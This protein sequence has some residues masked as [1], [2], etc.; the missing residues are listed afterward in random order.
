[1]CSSSESP[2][3]LPTSTAGVHIDGQVENRLD[4][5][6]AMKA[7]L[8]LFDLFVRARHAGRRL[9][10]RTA[11][12]ARST[13]KTATNNPVRAWRIDRAVGPC[14]SL[15][16]LLVTLLLIVGCSEKLDLTQSHEAAPA[17]DRKPVASVADAQSDAESPAGSMCQAANH[18]VHLA[19]QDPRNAVALLIR[20][21]DLHLRCG[22]FGL[23]ENDLRLAVEMAPES[24]SA[25]RALA[26]L[27]CAQ[28]RRV[29]ASKHIEQLIRLRDIKPTEVLSLVERRG[30][31]RLVSYD[32]LVKSAQLSL[33]DLGQLRQ[34]HAMNADLQQILTD[35]EKLRTAFP[36]SSAVA[37]FQGRLLVEMGQFDRFA[38][39]L[40][41]LPET[42]SD[43]PEYWSS[44]GTWL[45]EAD[46]HA[47]S[48]RAFGEAIRLDP[49]DRYSLRG[50]IGSLDS[51]SD[52]Q[53]SDDYELPDARELSTRL[54]QQLSIL[55]QIF[56]IAMNADPEQSQWIA[57]QMQELGRPWESLAWL[58]VAATKS[59]TLEAQQ[60]TLER[61]YQKIADW[62]HQASPDQIC[63]ARI[64]HFLGFQPRQFPLPDLADIAS[65]DRIPSR[66]QRSASFE[67]IDITTQSGLIATYDDSL[68]DHEV[69]QFAYQVNGSGVAVLDYD[70]DG[71]ADV[72]VVQAGGDP[73][74]RHGAE[75]NQ[76]FRLLPDQTYC[77]VSSLTATGDT[78]FGQGICAGDA[79]QDGF[80]DLIVANLGANSLYLN[81]GDG[82][83]RKVDD[84][85]RDD[86]ATWTSSIALADLNGDH[87]PEI[88]EI[89]YLDDA[90]AFDV[91]CEPN[92]LAC[93]P[94]QFNSAIDRV[95][96]GRT[97]GYFEASEMID[98]ANADAKLGFGVIVANF[99]Q[100]F[101]NDFFVSNDGDLNH[102]WKSDRDPDSDDPGYQLR[103]FAG[104]N[105]TS[106]GRN[107]NSQACMGI[108][109]ADFNR[110]GRLDLHVT[111]FHH[112]AVNLFVQ[113]R[114]GFFTDEALKYG[115]VELSFHLLGFGTQAIDFDNDGWVDLA[116]LNGHV[117]DARDQGVPFKMRPQVL[118]GG[119][120]GFAAAEPSEISAYWSQPRLGRALA[121]LDW[122]RDG[123]TDLLATHLDAPVAL[124]ENGSLTQNWLQFELVGTLS[125][126]DAIGAVV[127]VKAADDQWTQWQLGGDGLMVTNEP[128]IHFGLGS[129]DKI[130][131]IE[132]LWPSGLTQHFDATETNHRYLIIENE[133]TLFPRQ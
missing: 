120:N 59:G 132:V 61:R 9:S 14:P 92:Y 124:L 6:K 40:Q 21:F 39:W 70:L 58:V 10:R 127:R 93:Q 4:E 18:A 44:L 46:R 65:S 100:Q 72:Y 125:E 121:T 52:N 11:Y 130:D 1:M 66:P 77:D 112:E 131:E 3:Q 63:S 111:N 33:F 106:V 83:F 116:V 117:F 5:G 104:L 68:P 97:D 82:T 109:A 108:A 99:D 113:N 69:P 24:S 56:R 54:S 45:S 114:L 7:I 102:F 129:C 16:A 119:E 78:G 88:I 91:R 126:R 64:Q 13:A 81:Q 128:L 110:D 20:A 47:E 96:V 87:L 103:E 74:N 35:V 27:L 75:G 89:N 28:G 15:K 12:A 49:T 107:G 60:D 42:I 98:P 43:Q 133:P 95:Y 86:A 101:G 76:L 90:R 29:E 19:K 73:R 8:I 84:R 67:F 51:L 41:G 31:F 57:A 23:A 80:P 26:Q 105:G 34:D 79:N 36:E 71:R 32:S 37:A 22:E 85:I 115:L 2:I 25:H 38:T 118:Q 53:I 17:K 55:D 50:M 30:P 48:V 122:N 123:K 94:Q 62:Q